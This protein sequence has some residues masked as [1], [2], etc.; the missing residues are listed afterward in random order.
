MQLLRREGHL[1]PA[2][3]P[4]GSRVFLP[5]LPTDPPEAIE[6]ALGVLHRSSGHGLVPVPHVAATRVPSID[7]LERRLAAWQGAFDGQ[8]RELL[9][10]P[11][12]I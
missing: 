2:L 5:A 7:A 12:N 10:E 4:Y 6:Q 1:L 8:L 3:L 9:A 11:F